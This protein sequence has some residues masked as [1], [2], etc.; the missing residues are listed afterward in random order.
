[1]A[2][3][4]IPRVTLEQWRAFQAVVEYGGYAQAS[5]AVHK[6]QS[7]LSYAVRK[8]EQALGVA[9]LEVQG[10]KAR[11]TPAGE[12]LLRR[13][14]QLLESALV[15]EQLA[16]NLSRGVEARLD[17][18]VEVVYPYDDLLQVLAAFSRHFPDTRVELIES[19]LSGGHDLLLAGQVDILVSTVVPQGFVGEPLLRLEFVCVTSPDHPLQRFSRP[20]TL[21]DLKQQR[22]VVTRDS[23]PQRRFSAPW[24]E[25]EQRWTL[26]NITTAIRAIQRGLG[27]AW[28]PALQIREQLQQGTLVPV[29]MEEGGT[30]YG[31]L[32]LVYKDKDAAGPATRCLTNLLRER[33]AAMTSQA[34]PGESAG[35]PDPLA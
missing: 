8:L 16:E 29:T 11:L 30:R 34:E 12:G 33:C 26:S 35:D 23:G 15:L 9:V 18:A 14:R 20:V 6:T 19:V 5:E 21:Q 3:S 17:L 22:Q 7:T 27:F 28:L 32:Y 1:M 25:A 2:A 4:L 10:R 13:S 31:Q 24:L